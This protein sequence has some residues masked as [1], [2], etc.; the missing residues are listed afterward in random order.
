MDRKSIAQEYCVL[1]VNENGYF[2][3]LRQDDSKAGLLAAGMMDLM[4]ADVVTVERK[5]IAVGKALPW[6]LGHLAPLYAYLEERPHTLDKLM[7][8]YMLCGEKR[9]QEL[10]A[11][12]GE[13][14]AAAGAAVKGKGGLFG[15]KDLYL[16]EK[17]YKD[18]LVA[19]LRAV[20]AGEG[21]LSAHDGALV[22]ILKETK[23]L[24]QYFSRYESGRLRERLKGLRQNPQNRQ[25]AEIIGYLD[26][27]M[28]MVSMLLLMSAN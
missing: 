9:F 13:S 18:A 2:P 22:Y 25:L 1:A 27:T 19:Q 8:D 17:G 24:G 21:E 12:I 15:G 5:R 10:A 3:V 6:E 4:L 16:P 23:N 28:A 14:L 11:G 26:D 7:E 20:V